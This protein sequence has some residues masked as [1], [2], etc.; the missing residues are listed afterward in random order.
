M[1]PSS[2]TIP[3]VRLP[4]SPAPDVLYL[5][6][7]FLVC[8]FVVFVAGFL[9]LTFLDRELYFDEVNLYNPAYMFQH[10]G[11]IT[12]PMHGQFDAILVHPP[13]HYLVIGGFLRLGLTLPHAAAVEPVMLLATACLLLVFSR[14]SLSIK[15][16]LLFGTFLGALI[17]NVILTVRPD[18]SLALAWVAGLIALESARLSDWSTWRL[19][20]GSLLLV[21]ASAVHYPGVF[22]QAGIVVYAVWA[23]F[24]LP[25]R[26]L[27]ATIGTLLAG[28][29]L[30]GIPYLLLFAVPFRNQIWSTI[31]S[32]QGPG[33]PMIALRHHFQTY[34]IWAHGWSGIVHR[35]PLV[36]S[37]LF[38]LW[39]LHIPVALV[40]P[41]LLFAFRSTRALA[42]AALP[43]VLFIVFGARYKQP[44]YS[45]YYAPEAI[46][47]LSAVIAV[48][49][50]GVLYVLSRIKTSALSV[51]A[52]VLFVAGF[53]VFAL[54]DKPG[55]VT[56]VKFTRDLRDLDVGRAASR[57]ILGPSALVT[58]SGA[59][60]WYTSGAE[61]LYPV[62]WDLA[63]PPAI[64]EPTFRQYFSQFDAV[65]LDADEGWVAWNKERENLTSFL[66]SGDL[67]LMGFWF[68][69]RRQK[70]A[71]GLSLL[72]LTPN[73]QPVRGFASNRGK[74]YRFE[75]AHQA[76][77]VLFCAICPIG[78][79]Q[80]R[81]EFDFYATFFLPSKSNHDDPRSIT[82]PADPRSVIRVLLVSQQK[83]Q[84]DVLPRATRC[85]SRY[86]ITG[87]L[88]EV[89]QDAMVSQLRRNDRPIKFYRSIAAALGGA[90]RLNAANTEK[91]PGAIQ[92]DK[93]QPATAGTVLSKTPD[94]WQLTTDPA[95]AAAAAA[96][97]IENVN[98]VSSGYLYVRAKESEGAVGF[99][100]LNSRTYVPAA[101]EVLWEAHDPVNEIYIPVRSFDGV[102]RLVIRNSYGH[103]ASKI[104]IK[105]L[106]VV[107]VR[108]PSGS[109][110][111][112]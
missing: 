90:G 77:S 40:G 66:A 88:V 75:P 24:V 65:V 41:L 17:W 67:N 57:A 61:H 43:Q 72:M 46:L 49:F 31:Q 74:T 97:P 70:S 78:D 86:R 100:L 18:L 111:N 11:R 68:G 32:E 56:E 60:V 35:Q 96:I 48:F 23:C 92:L 79:L 102:D 83:F 8:A 69:D 112:R 87:R 10:Y 58:T 84:Q 25:R 104:L 59:G 44:G 20:I 107:T 103:G 34:D 82:D 16:G 51:V 5:R 45:G 12:Y 15:F 89:D 71:S 13:T 105:D 62:F 50:A 63:H 42:I 6:A 93:I 1:P 9:Y 94:G 4:A 37:L 64:A 30:I 2:E 53:T 106:A 81:G 14:F 33:G 36:Q 91:I 38:P 55:A 80:N 52:A 29:C 39:S 21:Y 98:G 54:H 3:P 28:P 73:E 76:D 22:A 110:A 26:R 108:P 47:Y 85:K 27:P 101:P 7:L 19:G 99:T 109:A 95:L